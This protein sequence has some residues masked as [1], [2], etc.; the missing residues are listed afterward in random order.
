[1]TE[2]MACNLS[3]TEPEP[4]IEYHVDGACKDNGSDNAAGG[5]GVFVSVNNIRNFSMRLP[6][7]NQTNNRAELSAAIIALEIAISNKDPKIIIASGSKYVKNGICQW[8]NSWKK[9]GWKT[10]KNSPVL[11]RDLWEEIDAVLSEALQSGMSVNWVWVHAHSGNV[12]NDTADQMAKDA[13]EGD[14]VP[15]GRLRTFV[16]S[17]GAATEE[18]AEAE[19]QSNAEAETQSNFTPVTRPS[20]I[21][22]PKKICPCGQA[23]TKAMIQCSKCQGLVHFKCC[24]LPVYQL[25]MLHST[26]RL[27]TCEQC[28][29]VPDN[30]I[31][32]CEGSAVSS[33]EDH[34]IGTTATTLP[35]GTPEMF[36]TLENNVVSAMEKL[37]E[38]KHALYIRDLENIIG[39]NAPLQAGVCVNEPA[40]HSECK[41][42]MQKLESVLREERYQAQLEL[43]MLTDRTNKETTTLLEKLKISESMVKHLKTENGT[44]QHRLEA[45][46]EEILSAELKQRNLSSELEKARDYGLV[47]IR[48]NV[49]FEL[50]CIYEDATPYLAFFQ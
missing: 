19:T 17:G 20:C 25:Y 50:G 13:C 26:K 2:K 36:K 1:M 45:K 27:F 11:N 29:K 7:T 34:Q 24:R 9:N 39:K 28:V 23:E 31:N 48:K 5:C 38:H 6:G 8:I 47:G 18:P 35:T 33:K 21:S 12:R 42:Q 14:P 32:L 16:A 37:C 4:V 3:F 44:L 46:S 15:A 49:L 30:F 22:P 43:A 41:Q 40:D 10:A